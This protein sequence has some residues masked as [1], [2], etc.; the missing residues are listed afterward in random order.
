[1]KRI[2][3]NIYLVAIIGLMGYIFF[4]QQCSDYKTPEGKQLVQ[5]SFLDSLIAVANEPP[6]T[7]SIDT[8]VTKVVIKYRDRPVPAKEPIPDNPEHRYYTESTNNDTLSFWIEA[9]VDG[10]LISWN[11]EHEIYYREIETLIEKPMPVPV[12]MPYEVLVSKHG[13]YAA[14]RVG[15]GAHATGVLF[16]VDLDLVT[17]KDHLYGLGYT[18]FGEFNLYAIKFGTKLFK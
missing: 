6:D 13:L 4:L 7:V 3:Q 5:E 11:W 16:G 14:M 9:L 17:K 8:I 12:P 15:G 2:L 18:R 10:E 1:M